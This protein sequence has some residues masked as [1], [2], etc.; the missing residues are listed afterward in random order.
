MDNNTD[1]RIIAV[2]TA[3]RLASAR[4]RQL[5]EDVRSLTT[6]NSRLTEE[7]SNLTFETHDLEELY[8]I[9]KYFDYW[10]FNARAKRTRRELSQLSSKQNQLI[11]D[12]DN[13]NNELQTLRVENQQLQAQISPP[14]INVQHSINTAHFFSGLK[15]CVVGS[16]I[17]HEVAS[18]RQD[19]DVLFPS[20]SLKV[21]RSFEKPKLTTTT[22]SGELN[23][24]HPEK[25]SDLSAL[26]PKNMATNVMCSIAVSNSVTI[27]LPYNL[28][29]SFFDIF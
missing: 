25:I 10:R 19:K 13:L 27:P 23:S 8:F 28:S 22:T 26:L 7:N 20:I 4:N 3:L 14:P 1:I 29:F 16:F 15:G 9:Q 21:K 11:L 12:R 17:T 6:E 24:L 5:N 2:Q 18:I